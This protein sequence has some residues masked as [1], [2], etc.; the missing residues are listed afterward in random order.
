MVVPLDLLVKQLHVGAIQKEKDGVSFLICNLT[1]ELYYML[2]YL[3]FFSVIINASVLS[4]SSLESC[5]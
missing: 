4:A 1:T 5:L 2:K 3:S